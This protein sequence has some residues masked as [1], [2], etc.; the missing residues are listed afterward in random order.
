M[1]NALKRGLDML[2]IGWGMR[3]I[4]Q[5]HTD[6]EKL[7]AQRAL[8]SLFAEARGVTMKVGQLFADAE[9]DTPFKE[10]LDNIE[11]LPL[12]AILPVI[13]AQLGES[14]ENIFTSI[15]E[16]SAAASLGQVHHAKLKDGTEVALK[17]RY[18]DI[19]D[20]VNSEMKLAGLMPGMGPVKRWG[21]DLEAY[22][23]TLKDNMDR[24]L[25]YY[26]EAARQI[27]YKHRVQLNGLHIPEICTDFTRS[28]LLVQ[29]WE[30]GENLDAAIHWPIEERQAIG[31]ILMQTLFKSL[32]EAGIV[33]GDPHMGNYYFRRDHGKPQVVLMDFGCTITISDAARL[34]L[35]KM[36]L[37]LK[38]NRDISII[39]CFAGMGFDVNKMQYIAA[40]MPGLAKILCRP[41]IQNRPIRMQ[42]WQ[43][44]D[45]VTNL[46]GD[47]RWWFRS[48]GPSELLLLLRAFQ[49][50]SRQLERLQVYQDWWEILYQSL[51][52]SLLQQA[53]EFVLPDIQLDADD[54][55]TL[56]DQATDLKVEV[57]KDGR[58]SVRVSLPADSA[59]NLEEIIPAEVLD[60][61]NR[62]TS[63]NM[64]NIKT[65]IQE[66]GLIPQNLFQLSRDNKRYHVW[67]E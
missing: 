12:E 36:I 11:P 18:P 48:A 40:A 33:H 46:L 13:D 60:E 37:A 63:V 23:N 6:A 38:E 42:D 65:Q 47:K 52:A 20:A 8:T 27:D 32:F 5:S 54:T 35:L 16:A 2:R 14:H 51:D 58:L 30:Q 21:F 15:D 66:N 25:D 49:G 24:E 22:K 45:P 55:S 29:S 57:Y 3:K 50:L 62:S 9:E 61:L 64:T 7:L 67:L 28:G 59:L 41:F 53:R 34:S 31:K 17:V 1:N 39:Q 10:L 4:G 56:A 44:K 19:I 43:V 26:S